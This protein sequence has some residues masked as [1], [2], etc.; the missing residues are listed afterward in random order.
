MTAVVLCTANQQDEILKK[1]TTDGVQFIFTSS[2]NEFETSTGD[3]FFNLLFDE[4]NPTFYKS[5]QLVFVNAVS[6]TCAQLPEN[7]IRINAWN[8]FIERTTIEIATTTHQQYVDKTMKA[9]GWNY[10]LVLDELGMIA[11]RIIAMIVNEAY[12]GL[13][14]GIST[15]DEIDIAMKLGTNYPRGPFE[16]SEKIGLD[17]IYQLLVV[18]SKQD[19]RYT[20]SLLLQ[21]TVQN[22]KS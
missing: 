6:T 13:E 20:P 5:N 18:L 3:V 14:D 17:K 12:F 8:G 9:F 7:C 19:S 2:A 4:I 10:Q 15:K 1:Q 11:P 22:L 21:Q 16:W